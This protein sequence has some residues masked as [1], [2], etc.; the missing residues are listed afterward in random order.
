MREAR[1]DKLLLFLKLRYG[2]QL[3]IDDE[4]QMAQVKYIMNMAQDEIGQLKLLDIK[5]E[6]DLVNYIFYLLEKDLDL[7]FTPPKSNKLKQNS[8]SEVKKGPTTSLKA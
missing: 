4:D 5:K 1:T 7:T 6:T 3:R 2:D 8:N